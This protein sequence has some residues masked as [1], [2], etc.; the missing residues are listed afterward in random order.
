M[1]YSNETRHLR[2][3][4]FPGI[5]LRL[6]LSYL[7]GMMVVMG[8][9]MVAV[10]QFF[11]H[12]LYQELDQELATIA[13]AAKHNQPPLPKGTDRPA[14]AM[15]PENHQLVLDNDGDLDLPLQDLQ[16]D[17]TVQWFTPEGQ[18]LGRIGH[19]I[20]VIPFDQAAQTSQQGNLRLLT[21]PIY[22]KNHPDQRPELQGYVRVSAP[23]DDIQKELNRLLTGFTVGGTITVILIGTTGWWLTRR[24]LKPIERSLQQL[25]QFTADASH[26]LRSPLTA[27]RT[28]IDVMKSHPER[29]HPANVQ[30]LAVIDIATNQMTHL[31][32]DL[33]LLARA[34]AT[35]QHSTIAQIP[36]PLDELLEDLVDM[37]QPQA[38]AK[39]VSLHGQVAGEIWVLGN[40]QELQRLFSN[41]LNNALQ[42]TL[43]G[44]QIQVSCGRQDSWVVVQVADTGIGIA[45]QYLGKVFDRFWRAEP[46]RSRRSQGTGLGLA[47]AQTIAQTH[48]G[49]IIVKSQLGVGSIFQVSLPAV[50]KKE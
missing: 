41:L 11:A 9:S 46:S 14:Q 8:V 15:G 50:S 19:G 38:E 7:G 18:E 24:S 6:L 17:Q 28:A 33:L 26:E 43:P 29:V 3:I 30:K 36:I 32:E 42:Y 20:P 25:Q 34:D 21:K 23:I 39:N 10:Y 47:I 5:S 40:A 45:P 22:R 16:T 37:L 27:I 49:K 4:S 48:S 31:V 44:G 12:S 35:T 1:P 13:D 2:S